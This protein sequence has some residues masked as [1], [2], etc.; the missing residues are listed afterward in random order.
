[1]N[2]PFYGRYMFVPGMVKPGTLPFILLKQKDNQCG[3]VIGEWAPCMYEP[4]Q[5]D[6]QTCPRVKDVRVD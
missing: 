2:C 4:D 5:A 6:W 3:L 1:M